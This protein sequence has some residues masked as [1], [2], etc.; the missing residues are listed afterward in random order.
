MNK[1]LSNAEKNSGIVYPVKRNITLPRASGI[2]PP[3]LASRVAGPSSANSQKIIHAIKPLERQST[4]TKDEPEI[5]NVLMV[6]P[7]SPAKNKFTKSENS[8][9]QTNL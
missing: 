7:D 6:L 1:I 5:N 9:K 4:F 3:K 2:V 8:S